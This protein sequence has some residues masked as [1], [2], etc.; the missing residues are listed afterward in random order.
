MPA[1]VTDPNK[2]VTDPL[3]LRELVRQGIDQDYVEFWKDYAMEHAGAKF[4]RDLKSN[5]RFMVVSGLPRV[6]AEGHGIEVGWLLSKN[7]YYAR[8]NRFSCVVD[9]GLVTVGV[10]A[11]KLTFHPQIFVNGIEYHHTGITLLQVDPDNENYRNNVLEWDY[12]IC[13]RRLRLI[14]GALLGRWV[15][16][17]NLNGEVRIKYNQSGDL[18][19]ILGEYRVSDD[20]EVIPQETFDEA[21]YPFRVSDS[22]TV[23]STSSDGYV[24]ADD[25]TY[26]TAHDQNDAD[27]KDSTSDFVAVMNNW[28]SPNYSIC[29][30]FTYFD[31]SSLGA[32]VSI[33]AATWSSCGYV[34]GEADS[35]QA[36]FGLVEGVQSDPFVNADYGNHLDK[37]TLGHDAYVAYADLVLEGYT[38]IALN[39]TGRGWINKTGTTKFAMRMSGDIDNST[40]A[41]YP[42]RYYLYSNEKGSGYQPKLVITYT[43]ITEK[44][45]SDTGQGAES[46]PGRAYV[47]PESGAGSESLASRLLGAME[48]GGGVEALLARLL[49]G[50][51][52]AV[53]LEVGAIFFLS[54]DTGAGTDAII[55][56][57]ARLTGADS[58]SGAD[59]AFLIKALFTADSGL[60]ADALV[61]LLVS[62][63]SD[64][65]MVG[66]DRRVAKIETAPTGGGMK[67]PPGGK[68]SISSGGKTSI[69]SRRVNP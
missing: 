35:G 62:I 41:G 43:A 15:F 38:D 27:S 45:S 33:S 63:V 56:L 17:E 7:K 31:T 23:Y 37:T 4:Y 49:T 20:E 21:E 28:Y 36:N 13:K 61:V 54:A 6:E 34:K 48:E 18:R 40:P 16:S 29:R 50:A 25:P 12:G 52:T 60:G 51:E 46:L 1:K 59:I 8:A 2:I 64:E 5:K 69:P 24:R 44:S 22:L 26:A 9:S 65:L 47:L 3:M 39:A 32:S 67:L 57:Q 42:N 30:G 19:L 10:S 14:E 68:T 55:N 66:S 53:G 11:K 58:G